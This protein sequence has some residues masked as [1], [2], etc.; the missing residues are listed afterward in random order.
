MSTE[1]L[2]PAEG[3]K[4]SSTGSSAITA[5]P[6]NV[7]KVKQLSPFRYPGGKTWLVPEI[8][9]WIRSLDFRPSVFVEPLRAVALPR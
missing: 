7:S 8:V 2:F 1:S 3:P 9:R 4:R 6:V 5:K